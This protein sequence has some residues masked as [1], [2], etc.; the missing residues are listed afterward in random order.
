[1]N[2]LVTGGA[3]FI[4]A[5]LAEGMLA[6]GHS[7][8]VI[9]NESTGKRENVPK[10]AAYFRGDVAVLEDLEKAF[11]GGLDAVCHIAGQVSIIRSFND[12]VA[13]LRTNTQGTVNALQLCLKYK[14]PRLIYASSMTNYG[15]TTV[16]PIP[17]SHPCEPMSYYGITKYAAE[18]YVQAT[19]SRA[20]LDFAFHVTSFRMYNVY[21][22]RQELDNP[23]QGVLGIFL[24]NLL[25]NEPITIFGDGEQSRDFIY[26]SDVV[27]AWVNALDHEGSFGRV[28][29]IG[30]GRRLTINQLADYVLQAFHQSRSTWEVRYLPARP[31]EQRHVEADIRLAA[32]AMDWKPTI[33]FEEGLAATLRWAVG[34]A[35]GAATRGG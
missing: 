20:D 33:S 34:S 17:E 12:P 18:R 7:V 16:L 5:H 29:N 14:V 22:S 4:G 2:V 3:G 23:Y 19:G 26:I 31:G 11:Q 10:G 32:S 15:H 1:M 13:D 27:R 25:R 21:G 30:S 6:A 28:F 35:A 24:G 8:V 9:D